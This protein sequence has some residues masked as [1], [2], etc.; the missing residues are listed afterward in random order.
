MGERLLD[1]RDLRVSFATEDGIVRAVAGVSFSLE[2]GEVIGIVGESGSGKS[3]TALTL[4]GL[5]RGENA[6]F[7]G[8][9][10]YRGRD[11]LT[12]S[13]D[14]MRDVRGGE[15]AMIFQ[16]PMT[17]MNPVQRVGAQIAEQ[18]RAHGDVSKAEARRQA[19]ELLREV[20]IPNPDERVDDYPHQFSGGMRQ[21][22]M[23][24]MALSCNPDIL[25]AD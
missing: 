10:E 7:S 3:V 15:I 12:L 9:A 22:A 5:T 1:V 16:D 2:R 13:E 21:R 17:A 23:I 4:L 19:I 11:L 24:A 18:V 14:E 25:N 6:H 20:G 8:T